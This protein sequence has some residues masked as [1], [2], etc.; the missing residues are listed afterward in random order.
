MSRSERK[1]LTLPPAVDK[2]IGRLAD[3]RGISESAVMKF[4]IERS[5]RQEAILARGGKILAREQDGREYILED[6]DYRQW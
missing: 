2:A 4:M 1:S 3:E 5:L 6:P